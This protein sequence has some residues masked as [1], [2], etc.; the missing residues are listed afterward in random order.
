M[1]DFNGIAKKLERAEENIYNLYAEMERFF[2]SCEYPVLPQDEPQTLA[3]AIDYHKNLSIPPRFSVLAGEV[4]HH[5]RSC[6]DHVAWHFTIGPVK[7]FRKIEFP[8][9]DEKPLN[10]DGRRLYDR[11][12][13]GI[14]DPKVRALIEDLQPYRA[15]DPL[16]DPLHIIHDFDISD[17]HRELILCVG[18]G[19][20][21]LPRSMQGVIE[22]YQREHPDADSAEVAR[23]F[24]S[25]GPTQPFVSFRNFGKRGIKS[26]T[27][28]LVELFN[29]TVRE[30][31]KFRLL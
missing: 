13:E 15:S 27:E 2:Q 18:T 9:F 1:Q 29:Y 30:I 28:G 24:K 7:N 5:L 19:G 25:Y 14:T 22:A 23:H 6:F 26:V 3:K 10:H 4:I 21:V 31:D 16:D 11:K 12:I 8:V 17:K 20:T